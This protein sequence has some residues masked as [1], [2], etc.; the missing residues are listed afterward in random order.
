LNV[1]C[2][3]QVRFVYRR[4][5]SSSWTGGVKLEVAVTAKIKEKN[6]YGFTSSENIS[7]QTLH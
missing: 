5:A 4:N 3:I 1:K 2:G 6:V 7:K